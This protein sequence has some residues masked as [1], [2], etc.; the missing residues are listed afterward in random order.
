MLPD[1]AATLGGDLGTRPPT[2]SHAP[3]SLP[4]CRARLACRPGLRVWTLDSVQAVKP[5][6][7]DQAPPPRAARYRAQGVPADA[8]TRL[9]LTSGQSRA[10]ICDGT[11]ARLPRHQPRQRDMTPVCQQSWR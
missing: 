3:G 2:A 10:S 1:L 9:D 8:A 7:R 11:C 5:G 6:C 4:A